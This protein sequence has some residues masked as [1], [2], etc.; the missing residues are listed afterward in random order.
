VKQEN[1]ISISWAPDDYL[2]NI[3]L[4]KGNDAADRLVARATSSPGDAPGFGKAPQWQRSV[5]RA[6]PLR[7]AS[8][9]I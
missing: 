9:A 8:G 6:V 4:V 1:E 3:S 7:P 5:A 2:V